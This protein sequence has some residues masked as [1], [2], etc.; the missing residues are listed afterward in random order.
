MESF[1][2]TYGPWALVLGASDGVGAAIAEEIAARGVGVVLV[3]RRRALLDEVAARLPV[4]SRVIVSDLAATDAVVEIDA[5]TADLDIGL[6]VYNAGADANSAPLLDQPLEYLA[7]LVQRN[8]AAVLETSY[9]FGGRLLTRGR[10]GLVLVTSGA[11]WAGGATLAAY[12]ASKAFDLTLAEALWAEWRPHGVSALALVLGAT[13]T[14][15][16]QRYLA[17]HGRAL[18]PLADP[19]DVA[20]EALDHLHDGPTWSYG[21]PDP[22]GGSP[23]GTLTRRDAVELMSSIAD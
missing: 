5:A 10:G 6:V 23:F 18:G 4:P 17:E 14:P 13:N 21:M 1:R 2:E 12:G 7:N 19:V 9:R 20:V 8:C 3:A 16:L 15:S 11:A 22:Q